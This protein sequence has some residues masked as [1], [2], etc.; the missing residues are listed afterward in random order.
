MGGLSW[1]HIR[2]GAE[3][4]RSVKLRRCSPNVAQDAQGFPGLPVE[5]NGSGDGSKHG[6]FCGSGM[7]QHGV[8]FHDGPCAV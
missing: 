2:D 3:S 4:H 1:L 6:G 7:G 8:A 5:C